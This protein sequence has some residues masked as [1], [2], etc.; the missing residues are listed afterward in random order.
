MKRFFLVFSVVFF[1]SNLFASGWVGSSQI[2]SYYVSGSGN[3][4]I[5]LQT[6]DV[7]AAIQNCPSQKYVYYPQTSNHF[8][9]VFSSVIVAKA[10]GSSMDFYVSGCSG[11]STGIIY[12]RGYG[13][14]SE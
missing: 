7:S 12:P 2:E 9:E 14:K 11:G 3:L 6:G 8:K 4:H 10:N 13:F 1:S 5:I